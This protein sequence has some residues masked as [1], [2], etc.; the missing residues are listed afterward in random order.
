[1][2]HL[3]FHEYLSMY[4]TWTSACTVHVTQ[5]NHFDGHLSCLRKAVLWLLLFYPFVNAWGNLTHYCQVLTELKSNFLKYD[6]MYVTCDYGLVTYKTFK[7]D[8]T[9]FGGIMVDKK[10]GNNMKWIHG[11]EKTSEVGLDSWYSLMHWQNNVR[12][13]TLDNIDLQ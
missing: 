9:M 8:C 7:F 4:V 6:I 1:M 10:T 3:S 2:L 5:I 11:D 12:N 13:V